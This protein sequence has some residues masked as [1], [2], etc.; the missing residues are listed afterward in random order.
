MPRIGRLIMLTKKW[1]PDLAFRTAR[2]AAWP[3]GKII[4]HTLAQLW[5]FIT[6]GTM[7]SWFSAVLRFHQM[8]LTRW[9]GVICA[10]SGSR[11]SDQA[12][13]SSTVSAGRLWQKSRLST[14]SVIMPWTQTIQL[15]STCTTKDQGEYLISVINKRWF[16]FAV[17]I[18]CHGV[19]LLIIICLDTYDCS[20][21]KFLWR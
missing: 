10:K 4:P 11:P 20:S 17:F 3:A 21:M 14:G 15:T 2:C 6:V 8:P 7:S 13:T 16:L 9:V 1:S 12:M 19:N 5:R 18:K